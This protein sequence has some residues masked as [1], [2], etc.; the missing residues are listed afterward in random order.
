MSTTVGA[1]VIGTIAGTIGSLVG[2]GGSFV[3]LPMLTARRM[4]LNMSQHTAIGTSMATV[5]FTSI[6]GCIAFASTDKGSPVARLLDRS[7]PLPTTVGNVHLP[8]A[9]YLAATAS[10][11]AVAGARLSRALPARALK[12]SLGVFMLCMVPAAQLKHFL[13]TSATARPADGGAAVDTPHPFSPYAPMNVRCGCIGV[14]SGLLAGL[15]GVGGGA[16]TVP[17]L[18]LFTPMDFRTILGTSLACMLPVATTGRCP[19]SL[20]SLP[21]LCDDQAR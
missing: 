3:A 15:F 20:P 11:A 2:M 14:C 1:Y 10:T 4:G 21:S 6:G 8:A 16:I 19:F 9:T 7:Q 12:V 18:A 5:F 17:A 13:K